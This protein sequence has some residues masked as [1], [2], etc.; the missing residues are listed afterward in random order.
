MTQGLDLVGDASS[1][2]PQA[3]CTTYPSS[4]PPCAAGTG[5]REE[6]ES[7]I[8]TPTPA[9]RKRKIEH[10]VVRDSVSLA[11]A[12]ISLLALAP[13]CAIAS[14]QAIRGS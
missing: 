6:S 4:R 9:P 1:N 3:T 7:P 14:C 12:G 13:S 11:F 5:V 10:Y 2:S 8:K